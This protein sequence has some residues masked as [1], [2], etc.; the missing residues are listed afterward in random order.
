MKSV[1]TKKVFKC[2]LCEKEF[3]HSGTLTLHKVIHTG[4]KPFQC[5]ICEKTFNKLGN[6][7]RHKQR[8]SEKNHSNVV[9]VK[10]HILIR[11]V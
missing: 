1:P 2:D 11:A 5:N 9:S 6:L 10:R 7:I 8:H 4:E 3:S